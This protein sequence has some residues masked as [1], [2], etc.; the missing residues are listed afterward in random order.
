MAEYRMTTFL[1]VLVA[2]GMVIF[3]FMT[4]LN[5]AN[6]NYN[7]DLSIN[8][9]AELEKYDP[10][11]DIT[12]IVEESDGSSEQT[13][14]VIVNFANDITGKIFSDAYASFK[15]TKQSLT[16]FN[17]MAD[18]AAE[19]PGIGQYIT[20]LKTIVLIIIVLGIIVSVLLGREV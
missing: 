20:Y 8:T 4:F 18:D 2:C 5:Q 3:G 11:K 19:T 17:S 9:T 16:S 7:Q 10:S 15:L 6:T 14:N 1:V 12:S 13:G